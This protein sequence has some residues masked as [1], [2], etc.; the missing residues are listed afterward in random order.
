MEE[1]EE[2]KVITNTP[3]YSISTLGKVKN[4]KTQKILKN[5]INNKQYVIVVLYKKNYL[6]HQLVATHYLPN[7]NNYLQIDHKNRNKNDNRLINLRWCN[8][9]LNQRNMVKQLN[10]SSIY[11]GVCWVKTNKKWSSQLYIN[12]KKIHFGFFENEKDAGLAYNK[13][14]IENK[15][16]FF[17]LN[18]I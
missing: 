10:K 7:I 9:S 11:K 3:N 16:E 15:L 14:I 6:I 17:V 4:N 8:N 18:D 1:S 13:Y 2:W 12:Y 5:K